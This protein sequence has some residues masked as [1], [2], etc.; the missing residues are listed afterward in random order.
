MPAGLFFLVARALSAWS[1]YRVFV[2]GSLVLE[3]HVVEHILDADAV[4]PLR[5][6]QEHMRHRMMTT[7]VLCFGEPRI[8][9]NGHDPVLSPVILNLVQDGLQKLVA[10]LYGQV[11]VAGKESFRL[12]NDLLLGALIG[13]KLPKA[14]LRGVLLLLQL[15]QLARQFVV[16]LPE[17]LQAVDALLHQRIG[18]VKLR[19]QLLPLRFDPLQL[20]LTVRN[21]LRKAHGIQLDLVAVQPAPQRVQDLRF[22]QRETG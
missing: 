5:V 13:L 8:Q 17:H 3:L 19:F 11:V 9:V 21:V 15:G 10:L 4:A 7:V 14:L 20:P 16:A 2:L 6:G 22:H 12:R 18:A 1:F